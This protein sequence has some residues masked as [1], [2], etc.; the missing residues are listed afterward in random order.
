MMN[1]KPILILLLLI[2]A[3]GNAQDLN[4]IR[5]QY[6][7][8]VEDNELV[9]QLDELLAGT[10]TT[11]VELLAYRGAINTLKAKFAKLK[12]EKKEFFKEGVALIEAAI[13]TQPENIEI[14]YIR[15]SVQKNSPKFLGYHKN[16]EE[17][18]GFILNNFESIVSK[19]LRQVIL[20][21]LLSSGEISDSEK[22]KL[23]R[24]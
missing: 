21:F 9:S 13:K 16:I 12:D 5:L 10:Q 7:K 14:R 22:I 23:G 18:K 17:D 20:E 3:F 6:P 4:K 11:A 1:L 19:D 8:A 24:G 2:S 15:L